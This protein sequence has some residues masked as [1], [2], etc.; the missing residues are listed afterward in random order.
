MKISEALQTVQAKKEYRELVQKYHSDIGGDHNTMVDINNAKDTGDEELH[1]IYQRL[2]VQK[3]QQSI[4]PDVNKKQIQEW[5]DII[6]AH[7]PGMFA[8]IVPDFDNRYYIEMTYKS[9][10]EV[11]KKH[12]FNIQ[13]CKSLNELAKKIK[14]AILK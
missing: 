8:T 14:D 11:I 9:G 2:M 6:L 10:N 7:Y 13:N 5:L 1:K 12:A 3:R 4:K